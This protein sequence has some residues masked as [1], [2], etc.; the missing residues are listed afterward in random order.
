MDKRRP[1]PDDTAAEAAELGRL[2]AG[3]IMD[4]AWDDDDV[5]LAENG[6]GPDGE[7]MS[8][9]DRLWDGSQWDPDRPARSMI[10]GREWIGRD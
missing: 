6:L 10:P 9:G 8:T 7:P 2:L 5:L 4:D 3:E 1:N